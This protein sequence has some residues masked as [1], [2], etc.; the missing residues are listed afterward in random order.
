VQ[1]LQEHVRQSVTD[2]V[3][4]HLISDVPVSIFLSAGIDSGTIAGLA[5]QLGAKVEGITIG[6]DELSASPEDEVPVAAE[7]AAH[8]GIP[9]SI[10]RITRAEFEQDIPHIL[11]AMDQPSID[12]VNTWFAS[13]AASERGYKV[14]LSGVGGDELFYGY[15]WM[16]QFPRN[17]MLSR[18]MGIVPGMRALLKA[19]FNYLANNYAHPK[20]KGV[21]EFM[22]S[23]EAAYFLKR[24][25]FLPPE[26]PILMGIERALEGLERLGGSPPAMVKADFVNTEA[27]ACMMDSTLYL[28]NQLL[29]DSDWTSM[30]FS[31]E[32]RTPL[33]DTTLLSAFK[34]FNTS[35]AG[36]TGKRLL[37]NSPINPL[38]QRIIN[39]PKSGF[40]IPMTKWL[41]AA[42]L[43]RDWTKMPI[44]AGP[45]VP[46]TRRWAKLVME[47]FIEIEKD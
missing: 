37:A 36:G 1:D 11:D 45:K 21:M 24:S 10:R 5:T 7:I 46:W 23:V 6:F 30:Q 27:G 14:V 16:K 39:R 17:V 29:R 47:S 12:G 41:A 4:A 44:L 19:P 34:D 8:Y 15:S 35:F 38:P 20:L 28:R 13:K 3:R 43:R 32:L 33:V 2:S 9:H 42:T 18:T 22:G 25:L 26:L 31:L 40:G